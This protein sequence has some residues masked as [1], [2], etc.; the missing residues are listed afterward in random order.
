MSAPLDA[1][2]P[3]AGREYG[4]GAK[5]WNFFVVVL[6]FL[7]V[8]PPVG[9][10]VFLAMLAL[11][12]GKSS[13]PGAVASVFAFLTLYGLLFSWFIGG[14]PAVLTGLV[15][16]IWQTFIGRV[17]ATL[18]AV[19]GVGAGLL[20][21]LAAGDIARDIGDPPMFPLYLVTCLAATMVCWLMARSFVTVGVRA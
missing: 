18:A 11:W 7:L 1:P 5:L 16:A 10:V 2:A 12:L 8:G 13:D 17:R 3:S 9:A 15:F 20:V 6:I 21:T 19:A 14:L 4:F